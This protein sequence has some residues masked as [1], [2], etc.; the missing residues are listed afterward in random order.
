[1]LAAVAAM[2]VP[3]LMLEGGV[4]PLPSLLERGIESLIPGLGDGNN[5]RGEPAAAPSRSGTLAGV[6]AGAGVVLPARS[7]PSSRGGISVSVASRTSLGATASR[8]ARAAGVRARGV[9]VRVPAPGVT[10][11]SAPT[12][13]SP[14]PTAGPGDGGRGPGSGGAGP[15]EPGAPAV[16]AGVNATASVGVEAG[17][18]SVTGT[19]TVSA[20][21]SGVSVAGTV[22]DVSIAADAS[23]PT[24][25]GEVSTPAVRLDTSQARVPDATVTV[26]SVAVSTAVGLTPA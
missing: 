2:L 7:G 20:S 26:G 6:T 5:S 10:G 15:G 25:T 3:L 9:A 22:A 14:P 24:N 17:S 18:S 1:V 11:T 16:P 4:F 23:V 21:T 13:G 8:G 19:A 12:G